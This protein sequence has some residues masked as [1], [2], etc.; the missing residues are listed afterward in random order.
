MVPI[1]YRLGREI[2][3]LFFEFSR[4]STISQHKL[5]GA[6]FVV[7]YLVKDTSSACQIEKD[8]KLFL[9]ALPYSLLLQT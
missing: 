2:C 1:Y 8:H 6:R 3:V 9:Q 5:A 7:L 4:N